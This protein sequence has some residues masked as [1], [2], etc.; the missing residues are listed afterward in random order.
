MNKVRGN[1]I[2]DISAFVL[3]LGSLVSGLV[4]WIVLPSGGGG[5]RAGQAA[6]HELF[7]GWER[8]AWKDLHNYVSLAFVGLIVIHLLLHWKWIRC[9]PR[10]FARGRGRT[11]APAVVG[12][13]PPES[14][15]SAGTPDDDGSRRR[16]G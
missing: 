2:V 12:D 13:V 6:A 7:L 8:G 15:A 11:C 9:I 14:C 1:A 3:L 10:F 4:T 5:P 16:T